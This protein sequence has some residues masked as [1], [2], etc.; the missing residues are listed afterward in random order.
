MVFRAALEPILINAMMI[1]IER[2]KRMLLM[3]T[4]VPI[5]ATRSNVSE[6]QASFHAHVVPCGTM[7]RKAR[8]GLG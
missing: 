6:N 3:G 8:L 7:M 2:E 1:V 4:G 5:T